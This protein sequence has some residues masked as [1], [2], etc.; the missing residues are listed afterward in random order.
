[1]ATVPHLGLGRGFLG[2]G[3]LIG[4]LPYPK[5]LDEAE[6]NVCP[7]TLRV[8]SPNLHFVF[9]HELPLLCILEMGP[10]GHLGSQGLKPCG[11]VRTPAKPS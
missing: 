2:L 5:V 1:M 6:T 8:L 11:G 9:R 4:G 10:L 7:P 3:L